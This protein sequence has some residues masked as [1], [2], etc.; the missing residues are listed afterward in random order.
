MNPDL[1]QQL[2]QSELEKYTSELDMAVENHAKW[3]S[4]INRS[5]ICNMAAED[6]DVSENPHLLCHF[7]R[8]YDNI[9]D[10]GLVADATFRHLGEVHRMMHLAAK[11]LLLKKRGHEPIEP[12]EYDELI[13]LTEELRFLINALRRELNHNLNLTAKLMGKVFENAGEGV[14]ITAPDTTIISVNKAFSEVTG[15]SAEEV[16]GKTPSMLQSG[17]Q[18]EAFYLHMWEALERDG[19]WQGEIW[20]ANK[21]GEIYLEWLSVTA[22]KDDDGNLSHYIGIFSDITSEKENEERLAHLAHYDQLTNL[23][24]RILFDD[25]LK[26]T[27]ALARRTRSRLAI[28]FLDLDG[29]KAIN[30]NLGHDAGD[31]LLKQVAKRLD[32]C[33]RSSDTVARFGGDEFTIILPEIDDKESVTRVATKIT[34]AIAKPYVI[35]GS[36]ARVTTSVGI[37]VYPVDGQHANTLLKKADKAMYHAKR[38]GKNHHEFYSG[39]E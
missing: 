22:V 33:L 2:T 7:G 19:Q 21:R 5:L 38:H 1:F 34:E 13:D 25:R 35:N 16:I 32:E 24:N 15:Y 23:P 11:D 12:V 26:Q 8:W 6:N 37:S 18:D 17:K 29:F 30:D 3:L 28:M 4:R 36:E 9:D 31:E 39:K 20:N 10:P 14:V 27:L